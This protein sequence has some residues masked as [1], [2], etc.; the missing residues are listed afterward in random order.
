M[1]SG[2]TKLLFDVQPVGGKQRDAGGKVKGSGYR[3]K[4]RCDLY[5]HFNTKSVCKQPEGWL[6]VLIV[7][8]D[9]D[10]LPPPATKPWRPLRLE[11]SGRFNPNHK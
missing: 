11:R 8:S 3:V 7:R 5:W 10:N 6:F 9:Q 1:R 4:R 2:A